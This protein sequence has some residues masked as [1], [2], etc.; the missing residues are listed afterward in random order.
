MLFDTSREGGYL[1]LSFISLAL[2]SGALLCDSDI[3][4]NAQSHRHRQ[5]YFAYQTPHV[6]AHNSGSIQNDPRVVT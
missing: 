5:H 4:E 1:S 2:K 6:Y 3:R